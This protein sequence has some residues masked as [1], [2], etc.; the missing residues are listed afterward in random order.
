M[1][2][3]T[4]YGD[5]IF[6]NSADNIIRCEGGDDLVSLSFGSDYVFGGEGNDEVSIYGDASDYFAWMAGS[7]YDL[8]N[9]NPDSQ[10]Y[11]RTINLESVE[12]ISFYG[13][14]NRTNYYSDI[15]SY[16]NLYSDNNDAPVMDTVGNQVIEE[17]TPFIYQ[18]SASD[19]DGDNLTFYIE[20]MD[21]W[22]HDWL[23]ITPDGLLTGTATENAVGTSN[24][25][26]GVSDGQGGTDVEHLELTITNLNDAPEFDLSEISILSNTL[27]QLKA[28]SFG[29]GISTQLIRTS[30]GACRID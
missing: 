6:D 7:R 14:D 8:K 26:V 27:S 11:G 12:Y 13:S 18:L 5:I 28:I 20:S 10:N 22:L 30:S 1:C 19:P 24:I 21:D 23:S 29:S 25:H 3:L 16:Y 15:E 2:N 9:I 17:E 4:D